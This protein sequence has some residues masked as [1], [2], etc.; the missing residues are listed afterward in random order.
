MVRH[1]FG[2]SVKE[3]VVGSGDRQVGDVVQNYPHI[4]PTKERLHKIRIA[5]DD[6]CRWCGDTATLRHR[7]LVC[8]EGRLQWAWTKGRIADMRRMD[9]KWIEL[10]DA[11]IPPQ[12][13]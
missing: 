10:S 2:K 8:G 12:L 11:C 13:R 7:L 6:K 9:P 3:L 5:S 4:F 1:G